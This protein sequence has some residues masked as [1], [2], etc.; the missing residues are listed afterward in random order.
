VPGVDGTVTI[1]DL[2]T[3]H[4][5][6]TLTWPTPREFAVFSGNDQ[7]IA[8]GGSDGTVAIWSLPTGQPSGQ[9]LRVGGGIVHAVFD[10]H[11]D[12]RVYVISRHGLSIWD[13]HD[14]Q[15][16]HQLATV[17]GINSDPADSNGP[18]L[19]I[20]AD[21]QLIAAG[22]I[23]PGSQSGP[24]QVWNTLTLTRTRTPV[25]S[26][27]G[28]IGIL[29]SD[30]HTL[31]F[32]YGGDTALVNTK[33]GRIQ[34]T[35]PNTGG[36]S[37]ATLSP[38]GHRIAVS[39]Q[40]GTASVVVV[41]DLTTMRPVGA[42]L[43]L[44]G[45]TAYPVGFLPDGRLVTSSHTEAGIWTLG[46]HLP[47][48]ATE[49]NTEQGSVD[50]GL[51]TTIFLPGLTHTILTGFGL[52]FFASPLQLHDAATG[53]ITGTLFNGAVEGTVAVSPDGRLIAAGSPR[54][55]VGIWN[56]QTGTRIAR[57]T[58]V[59]G[60][61]DLSWSPTGNLLAADLTTAVQLW[62]V[63]DPSHPSLV[64]DIPTAKPATLNYL[65]FTPDDRRLVTA[66]DAN[67]TIS[68]ITIADRRPAW[69]TTISDATHYQISLSPDGNTLAINSGDPNQGQLTLL[70]AATG[71]P[72]RSVPLPSYGGLAYLHHGQWLITTGDRTSPHA[73][74][75]DAS[76]L[77][78]I[79]APFPITDPYGDPI[80]VNNAGTMFSESEVNPLLWNVDP[81]DWIRT[82]CTIAG[83]NLTRA[84]WQQYLPTRPYR[85]TCPQWA[86]GT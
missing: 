29:S 53:R 78:P 37:L 17:P 50:P 75:R 6:H 51:A 15:H 27:Y 28:T 67:R 49:M 44:H 74:L 11:D 47:P 81:A 30:G 20:S 32:G 48:L 72:R 31:P 1:D 61:Y 3:G 46:Q 45:T 40:A 14:P 86:P 66:A 13:R 5:R 19:T 22:D 64:T 84:E 55:G 36:S 85:S 25:L 35:V 21:G 79:G 52:G 56:L 76:T 2:T 24:A 54:G 68:M 41:Y 73:Q 57:L 18:N 59:P 12:N 60:G 23:V 70:D 83:R 82:A 80:A 58:G 77:Q 39:E 71:T 62:N 69:S 65:L 10:P 16:P 26:F 9:P 34:A 43:R 7:L 4:V 63:S 42:P 33:T 8:A 38:D